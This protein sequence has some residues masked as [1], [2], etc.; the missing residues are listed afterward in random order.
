MK[1]GDIVSIATGH[2]FGGKPR[3]ALIIQSDAYAV[4][5]NVIAIPI[6]GT[7]AEPPSALRVRVEPTSD[8]GLQK[9]SELMTDLPLI[10]PRDRVGGHIGNLASEDVARVERALALVLGFAD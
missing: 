7:L 9:T 6:T 3:P 1:R 10:V 2:G 8:N 5:N 4:L